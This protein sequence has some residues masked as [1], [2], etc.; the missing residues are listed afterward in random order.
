MFQHP[1]IKIYTQYFA[2]H[3]SPDDAVWMYSKILLYIFING[4]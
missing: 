1:L 2:V 4:C 3:H